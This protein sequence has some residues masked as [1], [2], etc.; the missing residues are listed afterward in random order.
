MRRFA[1]AL[2]LLATF[3]SL[4]Q[5]AE[6]GESLHVYIITIERGDAVFEKFAHNVIWIH[7]DAAPPG[8]QDV[9]YNWGVFDFSQKGFF[10]KY[11][12]GHMEYLTT[13]DPLGE[14]V[15]WYQGQNRSMW[16]QELN[17]TPA[18]RLKVFERCE[19]NVLPENAT[20]PY[21]YYTDNCST[22]V[23]DMIDFATDGQFKPQLA[24]QQTDRTFRWHTR[25]LIQDD[26]LWYFALNTV[27]GPAI[28]RPITQWDEC[29]LPMLMR[30]YLRTAKNPAGEPLVKGEH[31]IFQSTR[32]PEPSAPPGRAWVLYFFLQGALVGGLIIW[33]GR[34]ARRTRG[35]RIGFGITLAIV[36]FLIGLGGFIGLWAWLFTDHWAT[37]RNENLFGYSPL[38][39]PIAFLVPAFI[40]R[41]PRHAKIVVNLSLAVAAT[42]LLGILISPLLPQYIAEPMA[43]ILPINLAIAF[44]TRRYLENSPASAQSA[45]VS[46]T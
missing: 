16:A 30:D 4:S 27:L 18:Q 17:L 3:P 15:L 25:R 32:P 8:Q 11:A 24:N 33:T 46:V 5:S 39:L 34:R 28:D 29:F 42:T 40:R 21:N 12:M 36:T 38:A 13:A 7:S 9:V 19:W 31:T 43:L 1:L 2:L 20:Y 22:R 23:R 6:P 35:G 26:L 41:S 37:W 10:I 44:S 14:T 45:T